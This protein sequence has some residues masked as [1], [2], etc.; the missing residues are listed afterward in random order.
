MLQSSGLSFRQARA[1]ALEQMGDPA[2]TARQLR[3]ADKPLRSW[4]LAVCRLLIVL[5]LAG[6]TVA[7]IRNEGAPFRRLDREQLLKTFQIIPD[8]NDENDAGERKTV[9][10]AR[11]WSCTDEAELGPWK[12]RCEDFLFQYC[13]KDYVSEEDRN[14]RSYLNTYCDLL[15]RLSARPWSKLLMLSSELRVEDSTGREYRVVPRAQR[16]APGEYVVLLNLSRSPSDRAE[17]LDV[18]IGKGEDAQRLRIYMESWAYDRD[19]LP[20]MPQT[21]ELLQTAEAEAKIFWIDCKWPQAVA[22]RHCDPASARTGETE[23]QIPAA[24]QTAFH[25]SSLERVLVE[26]NR[27]DR[28]WTASS[29]QEMMDVSYVECDLILRGPSDTLPVFE[30]ELLGCLRVTDAAGGAE[31]GSIGCWL[32]TTPHWYADGCCLRLIWEAIPGAEG[33]EL[34]YTPPTG[35]APCS[36]RIALGEEVTP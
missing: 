6:V 32:Q 18:L 28:E 17:W 19:A 34:Q 3:K 33:Y 13:R 25:I 20:E 31:A 22:V 35:G 8:E 10:A 2:K 11:P 7:L 15:L 5:M 12:I 30:E 36:L 27:P 26:R 23:L 14:T 4:C 24:K 21:S 1:K 16:A 29:V 9:I